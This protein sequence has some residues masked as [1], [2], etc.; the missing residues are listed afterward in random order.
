MDGRRFIVLL[1]DAQG[2]PAF[3]VKAGI[4]EAAQRLI[5]KESSFL[6]AVAS[7]IAGVPKICETFSSARRDALALEFVARVQSRQRAPPLASPGCA[8]RESPSGRKR[9]PKTKAS[10]VEKP[11]LA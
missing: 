11:E 6:R 5:Q 4:G 9:Q 3:V 7:G 8:R 2:R 10:A 1:F